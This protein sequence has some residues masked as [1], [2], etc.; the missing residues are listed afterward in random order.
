MSQNGEPTSVRFS[1]FRYVIAVCCRDP[2]AEC[3]GNGNG[4]ALPHT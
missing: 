3:N 1:L 2:F 4:N